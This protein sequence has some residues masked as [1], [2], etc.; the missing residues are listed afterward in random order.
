[1]LPF[2]TETDLEAQICADPEWQEGA[3]WGKPRKGHPEGRI[4][5]HIAQVLANID[6]EKLSPDERRSLRLIALIHDAFKYRVDT[7]KTAMGE[8]H[9]GM[10][11]R[12][13]AERYLTDPVILDIIQWHDAAYHCWQYGRHRGDWAQAEAYAVQL[14]QQLGPALPL[15]IHFFR[16]DNA[17][18]DKDPAPVAWFEE[19]LARKGFAIPPIAE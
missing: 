14:A 5:D 19:F 11:A 6:R 2:T 1:M 9:H 17:T 7:S 13:F 3:A 18:G 10:I 15:Y 12:H 8:N 4:A 16:A